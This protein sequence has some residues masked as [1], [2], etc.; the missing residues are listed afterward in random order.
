MGQDVQMGK[1]KSSG[2][3]MMGTLA[4]QMESVSHQ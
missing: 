2:D 3:G 4:Q 1:I